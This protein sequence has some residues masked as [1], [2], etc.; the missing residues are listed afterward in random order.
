MP[1]CSNQSLVKTL[2]ER[3][4]CLY[5]FIYRAG[6]KKQMAKS[7]V[8]IDMFQQ[9]QTASKLTELSQQIEYDNLHIGR[10]DCRIVGLGF[11]DYP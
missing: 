7:R 3:T 10:T 5:L 6:D 8:C 9:H 1:Q 11:I 4:A 2:I